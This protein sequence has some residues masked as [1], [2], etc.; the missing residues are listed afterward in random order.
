MIEQFD[1]KLLERDIAELSK[2][3]QGHSAAVEAPK[4]AI[5]SVIG[6]R[7]YPQGIPS[8]AGS[9]SAGERPISDSNSPLPNY[10]ATESP[11]ARLEVEKLIDMTIHMGLAHTIKDA[12]KRDP[13]TMKLFHDAITERLYVAFKRRGIIK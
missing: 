11:Q 10:A 2:E 8:I 6:D 4:E 9:G 7:L 12:Q 5:R 1:D 13:A 3:V